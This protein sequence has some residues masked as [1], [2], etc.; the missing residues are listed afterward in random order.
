MRMT[1]TALLLIAAL[2]VGCSSTDRKLNEQERLYN[3]NR[4]TL[5]RLER[6]YDFTKD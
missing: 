4:D 1:R 5:A 6:D 2:F 3:A